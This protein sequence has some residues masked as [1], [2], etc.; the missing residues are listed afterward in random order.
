MNIPTY[1]IVLLQIKCLS[2]IIELTNEILSY[3]CLCRWFIL[4]QQHHRDCSVSHL[5]FAHWSQT[6]LVVLGSSMFLP[7]L[8]IHP[9]GTPV[10]QHL[11]S[12]HLPDSGWHSRGCGGSDCAFLHYWCGF[13]RAP[14]YTWSLIQLVFQVNLPN[15]R[16]SFSDLK[17]LCFPRVLIIISKLW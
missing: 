10:S 7:Q 8:D 13:T 6:D 4:Y 3:I 9:I 16:N 11:V 14:G 17:E 2:H 5:S 15:R 12:L 1:S